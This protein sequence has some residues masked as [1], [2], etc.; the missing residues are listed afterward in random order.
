M[1]NGYFIVLCVF[2]KASRRI[3]YHT[4]TFIITRWLSVGQ[5]MMQP[6]ICSFYNPRSK[7]LKFNVDFAR[8]Y[9]FRLTL[10]LRLWRLATLAQRIG[11]VWA[12]WRWGC[13]G[14][15]RCRNLHCRWHWCLG[16]R[17]Q[18]RNPKRQTPIKNKS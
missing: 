17:P 10:V 4:S 6:L 14:C 18:L 1:D 11:R 2:S 15:W 5:R 3:H 7:I 12:Q 16:L 8:E 13:R 9:S